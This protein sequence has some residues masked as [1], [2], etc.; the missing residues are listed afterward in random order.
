MT[1]RIEHESCEIVSMVLGTQA[2]LT[3]ALTTANKCGRVECSDGRTIGSSEAY[4]HARARP[5]I[6]AFDRDREL[7]PKGAGHGAVV[8]AAL[9]KVDDANKAEWS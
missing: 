8:G 4:V 6:A 2:R 7:N 1:V 5:Q 3:I 9:L